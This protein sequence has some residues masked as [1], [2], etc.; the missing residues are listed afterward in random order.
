[1]FGAPHAASDGNGRRVTSN[2]INDGTYVMSGTALWW[3]IVG[4]SSPHAHGQM[5]AQA[6]IAGNSFSLSSFDVLVKQRP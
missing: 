4:A 3:A 6:V 2:P 1:M 5:P